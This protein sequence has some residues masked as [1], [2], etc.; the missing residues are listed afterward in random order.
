MHIPTL[1]NTVQPMVGTIWYPWK[2]SFV[3]AL[4]L[5]ICNGL[6][7]N[8]HITSTASA[9]LPCT[10]SQFESHCNL[11]DHYKPITAVHTIPLMFSLHNWKRQLL[12]ETH[13]IGTVSDKGAE[14]ARL[15]LPFLPYRVRCIPRILSWGDKIQ[16]QLQR[17][18]SGFHRWFW[19]D[20]GLSAGSLHPF[21][22]KGWRHLRPDVTNCSR[23]TPFRACKKFQ[24]SSVWWCYL[25]R[26]MF[27]SISH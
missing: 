5:L 15:T 9:S 8:T 21:S 10:F 6:C 20:V 26:L 1:Q 3:E 17:Q 2:G 25:S 7:C 22:Q 13:L 11:S 4:L 19:T 23:V 18:T 12:I 27:E 14:I 24:Q 16:W